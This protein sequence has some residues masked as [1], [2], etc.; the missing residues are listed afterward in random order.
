MWSIQ[1]RYPSN[2]ARI[3]N[4]GERA[5]GSSSYPRPR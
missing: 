2:R 1:S 4:P 3:W 5:D